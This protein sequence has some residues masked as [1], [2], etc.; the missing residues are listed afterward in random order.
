MFTY[1]TDRYGKYQLG[2]LRESAFDPLSRTCEFMLREEAHHMFVG[3]T[4]I[5]RIVERTAELMRTPDTADVRPY[6]GIDLP[7]SS[8]ISTSTTRCRSI[9]SEARRRPTR[10]T[11][12]RPA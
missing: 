5:G 4:G 8:G 6:G 11:I 7:T 2:A 1:F 10:R 3:T 9:C 12:S